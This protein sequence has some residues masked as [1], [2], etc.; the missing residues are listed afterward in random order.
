MVG[1]I[2]PLLGLASAGLAVNIGANNSAAEMGPAYGAGAR[3]RKQALL[4]IAIFC[5]A[6]SSQTTVTRLPSRAE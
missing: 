2:L 1:F 6:G 5:T 3:S 4:L